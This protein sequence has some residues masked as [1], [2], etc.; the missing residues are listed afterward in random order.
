MTYFTGIDVSLRSVSICV[1]DDHG[2][3]CREGKVDAH[4]DVVVD[5]LH[6]FGPGTDCVEKRD[7]HRDVL[8]DETKYRD[9]LC[10]TNWPDRRSG[11]SSCGR[12]RSKL[13]V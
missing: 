8:F 3:V 9:T 2:E 1:V 4:V 13:V 12:I 7:L 10:L 11:P 5:W 6:A